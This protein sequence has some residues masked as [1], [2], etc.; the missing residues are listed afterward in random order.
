MSN[1]ERAKPV[2]QIC[3]VGFMDAETFWPGHVEAIGKEVAIGVLVFPDG[4]LGGD[5]RTS[6][7]IGGDK[8]QGQVETRN[9]IYKFVDRPVDQEKTDNGLWGA[10]TPM[11]GQQ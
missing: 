11:M 7:I 2:Y 5:V 1:K 10:C 9:S 8:E 6:P 3:D 4:T